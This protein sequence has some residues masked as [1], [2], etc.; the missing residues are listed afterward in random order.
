MPLT[1]PELIILTFVPP[2]NGPLLGE[3]PSI[4]VFATY[5][6]LA[7]LS[8]NSLP[9]FNDTCTSYF[10]G[11]SAGA[12][13]EI[14]SEDILCPITRTSPKRHTS[15]EDP[16]KMFKLIPWTI[17][18]TFPSSGRTLGFSLEEPPGKSFL[19]GPKTSGRESAAEASTRNYFIDNR[20]I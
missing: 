13:H 10:P 2:L 1:Y 15:T 17:T 5:T 18:V 16:S 19:G 11:T 4:A 14:L 6:T 7:S 3:I 12:T 8:V 9:L 20:S